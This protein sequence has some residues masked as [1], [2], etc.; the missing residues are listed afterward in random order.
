M[1]KLLSRNYRDQFIT[2]NGT[3]VCR[4]III[5]TFK[6]NIPNAYSCLTVPNI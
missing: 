3:A 5:Y 6:I 4:Y 1:S 2:F